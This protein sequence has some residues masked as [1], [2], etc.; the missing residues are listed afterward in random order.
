VTRARVLG[1]LEALDTA[2]DLVRNQQPARLLWSAAPGLAISWVCLLLY[3]LERVEGVRSL[4]PWFALA[5]A[6]L[7]CARGLL[8][9]RLAGRC[10]EQLLGA[11]G[12]A[13]LHGPASSLLAGAICVGA[14]LW[15]WLWLLI[16]AL[17][18][19]PWFA[20]AA[21]PLFSLRGA[22]APSWLAAC[23]A[24]A[25]PGAVARAALRAA[26]GQRLLAVGAELLLLLGSVGLFFNLGALLA[27]FISLSQDLLGL[28]LSFVR[29][30]I[31][32]RNHFAL[33]GVAGLSLSAFEPLRAAFSAVLFA[34]Q[35]RAREGIGVRALVERC[36]AQ[37]ASGAARL[38]LLLGLLAPLQAWAQAE[39][40]GE[41]AA[42]TE[43]EP[44]P[45]AGSASAEEDCDET[46]S[47]AR[48]RDDQLL[49]QL[50]SIL[51]G[52]EFREFPEAAF[53]GELGEDAL[54]RWFE[55]FW[56]WLQGGDTPPRAATQRGRLPAAPSARVA[57]AAGL[58][59]LT[60]SVLL[61][62]A[63]ARRRRRPKPGARAAATQP[64]APAPE[65]SLQA[66]L[67]AQ[68]DP[69]EAL[70]LLY[71][72]SLS[73]LA[74]RGRLTL[75]HALTNGHYLAQLPEGPERTR[76]AELT[77][78]FDRARYG[79]L[80]PSGAELARSRTLAAALVR[81]QESR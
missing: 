74:R 38:A 31:S 58:F 79:A 57:L 63:S 64:E 19:D 29:A 1:T 24:A 81:G 76:L 78:L 15:L 36:L 51:E 45:G 37:G 65:L 17:S 16:A 59:L 66:A 2:I 69:H 60:T 13:P 40:A 47:E 21:L 8:L 34:E 41:L 68:N 11:D 27:A 52:H 26:D 54:A 44:P 73:G 32:P 71:L 5:L 75:S 22:L 42:E 35:R 55:G 56:R 25:T 4:R 3:Y 48:A 23:D 62:L 70:R 46:C 9:G 67:A 77:G 80:A 53:G 43:H 14:E 50:V 33:L 30:F 18:L 7:W 10:V 61:W 6:L 72:A 12:A 20:L 49:V 39:P 28:D